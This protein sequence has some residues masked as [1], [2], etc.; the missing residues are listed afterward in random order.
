MSLPAIGSVGPERHAGSSHR[1]HVCEY[2]FVRTT[3]AWPRCEDHA[4]ELRATG[5]RGLLVYCQDH[6]KK[7]DIA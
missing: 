1:G 4:G 2:E 3:P 6:K 7:L 5:V